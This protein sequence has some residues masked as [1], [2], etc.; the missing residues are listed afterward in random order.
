ML[1]PRCANARA[2]ARP[3]PAEAPVM[4]TTSGFLVVSAVPIAEHTATLRCSNV[5][6]DDVLNR[7]SSAYVPHLNQLL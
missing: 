4:T 2:V 5:R 1:A 7:R 3:T 6:S